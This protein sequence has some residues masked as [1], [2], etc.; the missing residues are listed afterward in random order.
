MS[1]WGRYEDSKPE[2]VDRGDSDYL[3]GEYRLAFG[4]GWKL[5]RGSRKDEPTEDES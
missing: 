1:I 4:R 5:W 3:L 2:L